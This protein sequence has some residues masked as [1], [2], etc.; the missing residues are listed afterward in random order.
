[1]NR[2]WVAVVVSR[3]SA[4][5][6]M[7]SFHWLPDIRFYAGVILLTR[8]YANMVVYT[9]EYL[10][11]LL[12]IDEALQL[13]C[14][15]SLTM[16]WA[17]IINWTQ[18]WIHP[19]ITKTSYRIQKTIDKAC[20]IVQYPILVV[21]R[22]IWSYQKCFDLFFSAIVNLYP[23]WLWSDLLR[24]S[25]SIQDAVFLRD[26]FHFTGKKVRKFWAYTNASY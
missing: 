18:L 7:S 17:R 3:D 23:A 15:L 16:G 24:W 19:K 25:S 6:S 26:H 12:E 11:A 20:F 21:W 8:W 14:E 1:M 5:S 4:M 9:V 22:D 10:C 2:F 13:R